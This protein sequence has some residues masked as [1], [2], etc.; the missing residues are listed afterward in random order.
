MKSQGRMLQRLLTAAVFL[1]LTAVVRAEEVAA[2]AAAADLK[3]ALVE[4]AASF[5]KDSGHDLKLAFG[6]L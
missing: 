6:C 1:S 2:I 5:R 3:Y 4:I